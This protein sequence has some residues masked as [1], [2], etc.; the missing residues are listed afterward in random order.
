M[1]TNDFS[2]SLLRIIRS[3]VP[4]FAAA[5]LLVFLS[6]H[7]ARRWKSEE[8]SVEIRPTI[9]PLSAINEYLELFRSSGLVRAADGDFEYAPAAPDLEEAIG[10][11]VL[12]Y[13][14][15]PVTLIRTIYTIADLKIQ[16]F[17]DSFRLKPK[18]LDD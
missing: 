8:I 15:R 6:R 17:A 4:T 12:A 10:E 2:P 3:C 16:S 5:E 1:G 11:L 7:P 9:I 13:N 14:E 18:A